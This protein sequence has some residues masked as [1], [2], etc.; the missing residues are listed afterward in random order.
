MIELRRRELGAELRRVPEERR[1]RAI[2]IMEDRIDVVEIELAESPHPLRRIVVQDHGAARRTQQVDVRAA[3]KEAKAEFFERLRELLRELAGRRAAAAAL[4]EGMCAIELVHIRVLF[5]FPC[6]AALI[7]NGEAAR[8][9]LPTTPFPY[10]PGHP[11]SC[12]RSF[13]PER[14]RC[15]LRHFGKN[16]P[17]EDK[18]GFVITPA[19]S[20]P[21][22]S[23]TEDEHWRAVSAICQITARMILPLCSLLSMRA[24]ARPAS[25]RANTESTTG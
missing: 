15:S 3:R 5:G 25:A 8:E 12:R 4:D 2:R 17:Q 16:V 13:L 24:C 6:R 11:L 19:L 20:P 9:L 23:A 18:Y 21:Q 1:E 22:V 14:Q 7:V 10:G